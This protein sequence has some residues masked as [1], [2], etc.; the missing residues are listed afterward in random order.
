MAELISPLGCA[1]MSVWPQIQIVRRTKTASAQPRV[2]TGRVAQ[3][4]VDATAAATPARLAHQD[5]LAAGISGED[6]SGGIW[7][8]LSVRLM[9]VGRQVPGV[10]RC[11]FTLEGRCPVVAY[12]MTACRTVSGWTRASSAGTVASPPSGDSITVIGPTGSRSTA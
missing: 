2:N 8:L 11:Q 3:R 9:R 4:K 7:A 10:V 6:W 12:S 5:A 1:V